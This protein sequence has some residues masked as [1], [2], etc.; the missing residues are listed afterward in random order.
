M[1]RGNHL[2]HYQENEPSKKDGLPF[3]EVCNGNFAPSLLRR[4]GKE[5]IE[6]EDP[7]SFLSELP[8]KY[9]ARVDVEDKVD[10]DG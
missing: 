3:V 5:I 8:G 7:L 1:W 2:L 4:Y 10:L 9:E 6:E